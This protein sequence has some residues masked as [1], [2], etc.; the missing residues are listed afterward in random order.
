MPLE[1]DGQQRCCA[2]RERPYRRR[3]HRRAAH[4][5]APLPLKPL[6]DAHITEHMSA[7]QLDGVSQIVLQ[8]SV[9]T[10]LS[11]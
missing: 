5:A 4:G 8:S 6:P 3:P 10:G 2:V 7:V 1:D 9:S 11:A